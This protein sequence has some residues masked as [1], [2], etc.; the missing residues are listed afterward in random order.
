VPSPPENAPP[1][2]VN[3][4]DRDKAVQRLQ[5][6]YSAGYI[7][8]EEMEER[9]E[10]ALK[11]KTRG[12]L[13]E[14]MDALPAEDAPATSTISAA[15]GRIKRRGAWRVPRFLKVESSFGKVNLD[16]SRAVFEHSEVDIEL[17]LGTGR[18]KITVP[19][20]AVV[21]LEGLK[22]VWKPTHYKPPRSQRPGGPKIRIIGAMGMGRLKV[23]H[24]RR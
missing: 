4:D 15:T 18:A 3:D 21:D 1:P 17:H 7:S 22:T 2:R 23:R 20:D 16:L 14:A 8:H 12:D 10:Q 19:R 11:A 24:S 13:V 5:E 6:A 9:L